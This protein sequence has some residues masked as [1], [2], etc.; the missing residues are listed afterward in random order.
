VPV[1]QGI[2]LLVEG[3]TK[4]ARKAFAAARN[5][6]LEELSQVLVRLAQAY[7]AYGSPGTNGPSD[8]KRVAQLLSQSAIVARDSGV[9]DEDLAEALRLAREALHG[10][11]KA[12]DSFVRALVCHLRLLLG[13][14][15]EVE[16]Q[17]SQGGDLQRPVPVVRFS[18]PY[19]DAAL[20]AR[21]QG[22][23]IFQTVIDEEGCVVR[24]KVLKGLPMGLDEAT[25]RTSLWWAFEPASLEGE[26]VP[27]YYNFTIN[28][29]IG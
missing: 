2:K 4:P 8:H 13:L 28:F 7:T 25:R 16:E 23:V 14:A 1:R 24:T 11:P 21:L 26:A 15:P 29:S 6:G 10:D 5:G 20:Q 27:V 18:A 22:V 17:E 12:S 19:T 3:K 9:T